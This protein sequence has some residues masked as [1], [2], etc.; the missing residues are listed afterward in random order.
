MSSKELTASVGRDVGELS[1]P[2]RSVPGMVGWGQVLGRRLDRHFLTEPGTSAAD[3]AAGLCGVH[4][5]IMAA[6]EL[7]I[8]Q[9]LAGG[10][11][12]GVRAAL[13]ETRELVKTFG[14]RGTV[15]LLADRGPAGVDRRAGRGPRAAAD[16]RAPSVRLTTGADRRRSW[17]A[18]AVLL[19]DAELTPTS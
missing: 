19:A 9:R 10:G 4:A 18:I 6:A 11:R 13:W 1:V 8:G 5:Q 2:G 14:P 3:V 17:P 7:S 16:V 12:D 15:H